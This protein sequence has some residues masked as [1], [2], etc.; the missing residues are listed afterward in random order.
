MTGN[1]CYF[2]GLCYPQIVCYYLLL[3]HMTPA[4]DPKQYSG[5]GRTDGRTDGRTGERTE[6]GRADGRKG[7]RRSG[8]A[9]GRAR[10]YNDFHRF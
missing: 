3:Y 2:F 8:R 6:D 4:R 9:D 1:V 5:G 10:Q 7:G